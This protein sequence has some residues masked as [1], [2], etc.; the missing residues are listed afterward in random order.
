MRS[1]F[2]RGQIAAGGFLAGL[3]ITVAV[4]ASTLSAGTVATCG[5][6]AE[7]STSESQSFTPYAARRTTLPE[8]PINPSG[9]PMPALPLDVAGSVDSIDGMSI[10]WAVVMDTGAVYRYFFDRAIAA[11]MT[12][13]DFAAGGGI[14]LHREI[15][16]EGD[17]F[18]A[19]LLAEFP[20]RAVPVTV[21][22]HK[23]VVVWGDPDV[24]GTRKHN[25]YWSNGAENYSLSANRSAAQLVTLARIITCR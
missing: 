21:G 18:W 10:R 8:L 4:G 7:G 11:S 12:P 22:Q 14:E 25:V 24:R 17:P 19:F 15:L 20:D 2:G 5:P 6:V 23:G 1:Y 3:A 16:A 9:A 13:A